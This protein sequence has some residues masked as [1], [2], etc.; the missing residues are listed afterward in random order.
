MRSIVCHKVGID[1]QNPELGRA[2]E[3]ADVCELQHDRLNRQSM[4]FRRHR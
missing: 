3:Y 2:Q 4:T 1:E